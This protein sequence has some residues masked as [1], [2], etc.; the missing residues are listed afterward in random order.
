MFNEQTMKGKWT[1]IKGEIRT[2]WGKLTENEVDQASG[3]LTSLAGI[4]QQRY[5]IKKEEAQEK[6]QK[7][8]S[9]FVK[10]TEDVKEEARKKVS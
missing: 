10:V 5:G 7:I 1:E 2:Q 3:N 4:I 9:K 8:A 6:L